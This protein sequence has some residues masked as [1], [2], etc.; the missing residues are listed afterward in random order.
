MPL[1]ALPGVAGRGTVVVMAAASQARFSGP[2]KYPLSARTCSSSH[3]SA[4]LA[5]IAIGLICSRSKPWFVT[6]CA[7]HDVRLGVDGA[8][9]CKLR[10]EAAEAN[11][12]SLQAEKMAAIGHLAGGVAHDFN[13]NLTA[14]LGHLEVLTLVA[15]PKSA[16]PRST[17]PRSRPDSRPG[18]SSNSGPSPAK[19]AWL[20]PCSTVQRFSMGSWR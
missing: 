1:A 16:A 6:S 17:K 12:R 8:L 10:I 7:T 3:P 19:I 14:V 9:A 18:W 4:S 11:L 13:N 20:W 5:A 15:P 2:L